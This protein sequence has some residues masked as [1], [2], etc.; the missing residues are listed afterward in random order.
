MPVVLETSRFRLRPLVIHDLAKDY[1]AVMITR[2]YL[3]DL[4]GEV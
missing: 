1:E 2:E 4:F 3:W